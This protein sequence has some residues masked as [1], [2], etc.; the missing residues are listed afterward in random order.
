MIKFVIGDK[1]VVRRVD[2]NMKLNEFRDSLKEI[3][4]ESSLFLM[5]DAIIEKETESDI[6]I[7]DIIKGKEVYCS[8]NSKEINIILNGKNI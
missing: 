6:T 7:K 3:M 1:K 5:E 4:P 8:T 2:L